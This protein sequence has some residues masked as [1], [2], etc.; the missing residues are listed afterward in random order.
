M[1]PLEREVHGA[2][3]PVAHKRTTRRTSGVAESAAAAAAVQL[4][5]T[6]APKARGAKGR[7]GGKAAPAEAAAA[8]SGTTTPAAGEVRR[9][10]AVQHESMLGAAARLTAP[11]TPGAA[12]PVA[13]PAH[14]LAPPHLP[15]PAFANSSLVPSPSRSPTRL[16]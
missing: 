5:V 2:V 14:C 11:D 7:G 9:G 13:A 4:D 15:R 10:A 8:A 12:R 16:A 1:A 3:A 6:L